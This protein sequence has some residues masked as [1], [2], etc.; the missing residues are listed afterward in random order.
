VPKSEEWKNV[1]SIFPL[2]DHTFNKHWISKWSTTSQL[3][4]E[5]LDEI[6]D[7]LG[8]K[9]AFYFAFTNSYFSFL[10]FPAVFGFS[11][12]V[13]LGYFSPIYA[14]VNTLWCVTFV[15]Y[16]KQQEVDLGIRWGVRG[17]SEIQEKRHDFKYEKEVKDPITGE[18]KQVFPALKRLGRQALAVPFGILAMIALGTIIATCFGI[19]IFLSEVYNG[20]FKH[21]LVYL[22]T[23]LLTAFVP[24]MSTILTTVA[25]K[26]NDFENYETT[27][28]YKSALTAKIFILNFITSYFPV[29]LT[30]FV[31]IPFGSII[32]PHLDVFHIT[33][34]AFAENDAQLKAPQSGFEINPHRLR[35]QVIYFTVTAQIVNFL[36]ETVVPYIKR[37]GF[38]K[39][40]SVKAERA[41]RR[42]GANPDPS[43]N[44]HAEETDFLTRVRNEAELPG[45]DVTD[46]LREMVIQFG[47]L[48]L[49]SVVWPLVPV[50]FLINNWIELRSDAVK[51]CIE[52]QRPTP[53]RSDGIGPW[54]DSLS[55]LSWLGSVTTAALVYLFSND[56]LGPDGTPATI[57]GWALLLTIFFS[58]HIYLVVRLAVRTAI[59]KIDSP[60]VQKERAERY[61]VRKRYLQEQFGDK[62]M[63]L[64]SAP[65]EKITRQSLEEDA[66]AGSLKSSSSTD[67]FWARQKGWEESAQVGKSLIDKMAPAESKKER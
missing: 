47:Y 3:K 9:V 14:V 38:R 19:E 1:E 13:L 52:S 10:M 55:F 17:V 67:R 33:A 8:E 61:M 34:R 28:G 4:I 31:Y 25:T 37:K 7:R 11:A 60:G 18:T 53:F 44:D 50:S 15:E 51:I 40:Q 22:P 64:P 27:E 45:Y 5:D 6:R 24:T 30:A 63:E 2:H 39:Y 41:A 35:T 42:G 36:M 59:S 29:F 49:F 32:V 58:E 48:S 56:G 46:D 65:H 54:L 26:L 20:P 16:W 66:R 57:K 12:W 43:I 21:L 62:A 23:V